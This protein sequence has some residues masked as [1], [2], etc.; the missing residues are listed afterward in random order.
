[1]PKAK[2]SDGWLIYEYKNIPIGK[3]DI[4]LKTNKNNLIMFI[5]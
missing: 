3:V 1:M 2:S 5:S 4:K